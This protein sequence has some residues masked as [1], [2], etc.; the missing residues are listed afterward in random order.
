MD[1][2]D[3]QMRL[4]SNFVVENLE[5]HL[6][7]NIQH[8]DTY[9]KMRTEVVSFLEQKAS[10]V[11]DGGA[12]PM[13]L[14]YVQG[15]GKGKTSNTKQLCCY[16]NKPG[17]LARDCRLKQSESSNA[18]KGSKGSKGSKGKSKSSKGS[19]KGSSKG[20]SKGKGKMG[21]KS[22][23]GTLKGKTGKNH[24]AEGEEPEAEGQEEWNDDWPEIQQWSTEEGKREDAGEQGALCQQFCFSTCGNG[25]TAT[26]TEAFQQEG[27]GALEDPERLR[28]G[29]DLEEA[30][31]VL[32]YAIQVGLQ[33]ERL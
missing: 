21:A 10:K 18:Q 19:P 22:S 1:R 32:D 9:T 2:P 8:F 29:Q 4:W 26:S 5:E 17:H 24:A 14:D 3:H 33:Q 25:G 11:D 20:T 31:F 27:F 15:K 6:E 7:L 16:C 12:Q 30:V 13:D 28:D 23:K